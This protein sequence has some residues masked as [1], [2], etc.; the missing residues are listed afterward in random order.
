[1]LRGPVFLTITTT[2]KLPPLYE[3]GQWILV[4]EDILEI[5]EQ[6]LRNQIVGEYLVK[7]N[8]LSIEDATWEAD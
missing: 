2:T 3:E 4:P 7:W 5:R 6:K 8:N 1:L